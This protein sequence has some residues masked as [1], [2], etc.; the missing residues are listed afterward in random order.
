M[1]LEPLELFMKSFKS[2]IATLMEI[3]LGDERLRIYYSN[4]IC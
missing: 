3:R 4:K 1:K 2:E